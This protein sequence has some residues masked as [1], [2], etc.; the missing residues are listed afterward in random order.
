MLNSSYGC[1]LLQDLSQALDVV[2]AA[3]KDSIRKL[4]SFDK[5][6][7]EVF[8]GIW[9]GLQCTKILSFGVKT[10][11]SLKKMTTRF[12][13]ASLFF[14][15]RYFGVWLLGKF[16]N[17]VYIINHSRSVVCE[18]TFIILQLLTSCF[19]VCAG[20]THLDHTIGQLPGS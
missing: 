18:F 16:L 12:V 3:L 19:F 15:R 20:T 2:D 1:S 10:S 9:T 4:S 14:G 8:S 13:V 11:P 5:Y 6:K 17:T 7:A